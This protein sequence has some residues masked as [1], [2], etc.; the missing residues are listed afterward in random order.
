M[1]S[2]I[3]PR[4]PRALAL[5]AVPFVLA[6]GAACASTPS[7]PQTSSAGG[8]ACSAHVEAARKKVQAAI[9]ANMT[10]ASDADCTDVGFG[11]SCFDS[12]SRPMASAGMAA[13]DAARKDA[14]ASDCK[15]YEDDGC[16][17]MISP[18]CAPPGPHVCKQGR[19][20]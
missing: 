4:L 20:E 14:D 16:P 8:D 3:R 12:C 6:L 18:P 9:D 11:A 5:L 2:M 19:C 7:A 15:A 17:P 10:C 1:N 13:F